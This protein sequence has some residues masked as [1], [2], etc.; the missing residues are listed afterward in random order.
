[1]S[2]KTNFYV[3]KWLLATMLILTVVAVF[4]QFFPKSVESP[5]SELKNQPLVKVR[6]LSGRE[7]ALG[8]ILY[9]GTTDNSPSSSNKTTLKT[10]DSSDG[11]IGI[12]SQDLYNRYPANKLTLDNQIKSEALDQKAIVLTSTGKSEKIIV[13]AWAGKDGLTSIEI[14]K[15]TL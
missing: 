7:L 6:E 10:T 9:P 12:Y 4:L 14:E 13:I 11:V 2:K 1:M 8:T 3:P 5:L 15:H